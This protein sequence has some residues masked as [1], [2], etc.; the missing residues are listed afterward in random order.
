MQRDEYRLAPRSA[1]ALRRRRGEGG[2]KEADVARL[3]LGRDALVDAP[4]PLQ[5][6]R[7]REQGVATVDEERERGAQ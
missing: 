4:Q 3:V 2:G 1:Q 5:P 6:A 7:V